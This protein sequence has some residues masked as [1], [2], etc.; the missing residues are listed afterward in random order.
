M[1]LAPLGLLLATA[2]AGV[3]A[4]HSQCFGAWYS[5]CPGLKVLA[6]YDCEDARGLLKAAIRDPDPVIFLENELLYGNSYPVDDKILDF[7]FTVPIGKAKVMREG[8]D[9]TLVAFSKMVGYSLEAAEVLASA[10]RRV[11]A[12]T[13]HASPAHA[14]GPKTTGSPSTW[15]ATPK[16]APT[17]ATS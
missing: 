14:A 8:T 10:K 2:A 1:P 6:P 4:Q 13:P 7:D 3:G 11:A 17:A 9:V 12:A 5:S 16:L 15:S